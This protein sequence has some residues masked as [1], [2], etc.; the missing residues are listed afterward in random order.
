MSFENVNQLETNASNAVKNLMS[1]YSHCPLFMNCVNL[2][3]A[4]S[5]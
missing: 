5:T 4:E 2:W 1:V 3:T